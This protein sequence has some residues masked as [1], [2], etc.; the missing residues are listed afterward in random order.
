[1]N[2]T[3]QVQLRGVSFH[4]NNTVAKIGRAFNTKKNT[5]FMRRC[6]K[7]EQHSDVG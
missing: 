5:R 3:K 7:K 1:L 6:G 2:Q 4:F